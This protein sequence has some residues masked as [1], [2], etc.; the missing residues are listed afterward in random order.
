M[1]IST[2][3]CLSGLAPKQTFTR[4]TSIDHFALEA[5]TPTRLFLAGEHCHMA[6][7]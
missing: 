5:D 4:S 1:R 2:A 7:R 3:L 6:N